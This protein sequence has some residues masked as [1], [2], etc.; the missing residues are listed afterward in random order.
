VILYNLIASPF[1][2]LLLVTGVGTLLLF[3]AVNGVAFGRDLGEM[4]ASRHGDRVSRKAWLANTRGQRAGV[5][6]IVTGL[7]LVP[8]VNLIAPVLGAA[9][10][11]HLYH[12]ARRDRA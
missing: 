10:A 12:G 11:T 7:F 3:V 2:L 9:M 1:Y 5:G 6:A 8:I 4:V